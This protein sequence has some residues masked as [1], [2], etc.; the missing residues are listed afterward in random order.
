MPT[1]HFNWTEEK[2]EAVIKALENWIIK[3]RAVAGE[4][5]MQSDDCIIYAPEL[6]SDIVDDIIKPEYDYEEED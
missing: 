5:I 1:I 4:V 2:K 3:H 6:I